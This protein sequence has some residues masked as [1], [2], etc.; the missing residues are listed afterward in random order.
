MIVTMYELLRRLEKKESERDFLRVGLVGCGQMGSGMVNLTYKMP[1]L[2]IV[3]IA[4]LEIERG[5][6]AFEEVG[7]RREDIVVTEK[8]TEACEALSNGKVVVSPSALLLTQV[9]MLSA[10]VE[11]T[12]FPE[13]GAQ[14]AWHGILNG[15]NVVMLNVETDVTVGWIL[16]RVADRAGVVYT[17]SAGDEPGAVI[18]LYRFAKI[19]GFQ[20]VCIGKGKNNPVDF[21]ATPDECGEEALRKGMNPKMLCSF[22]DGTKTMVEMAEVSNATGALPDVPGMHGAKVDVSE[23]PKIYIPKKDGGLFERSF[24]VD[25]STG[26]VAPGVFVVVTTDSSHLRQ[27]LKFYSMGDGPYYVLYRPY[28]LCSFETPISVAKACL[29]GEPTINSLNFC[30]EVVAVAKRDLA[31]GQSIDGIGGFDVF[32]KIYTFGEAKAKNAVPIGIIQGAKVV[33]S[34]PKGEI[35]TYHDV[36]LDHNLFVVKLRG[37]QDMLMADRERERAGCVG[38]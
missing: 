32:G 21:F 3:A 34:I 15:K 18:E 22:V 12:G 2:R 35:I 36:M 38:V 17:V 8:L 26:K 19:L 11:A 24:V 10:L 13:V 4:D 37:M 27:D 30:S 14:V 16:K 29:F 25:Y 20:V 28:H 9:E 23:L 31:P 1:G 7:F 5:I 6:R 33:R